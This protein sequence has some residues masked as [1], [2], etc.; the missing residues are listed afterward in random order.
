MDKW[1]FYALTAF[2][3]WGV[4]GLLGASTRTDSSISRTSTTTGSNEDKDR[5]GSIAE[6]RE[7]VG[8]PGGWG[9]HLSPG[10]RRSE[11]PHGPGVGFGRFDVAIPRFG[12]SHE[13][14][15]KPR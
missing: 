7:L 6:V 2:F 1:M 11:T 4:W 3:L 9:S 15:Q 10:P 8:F 13:R 12:G 14:A 5:V